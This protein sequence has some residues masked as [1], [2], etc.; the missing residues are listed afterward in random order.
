MCLCTVKNPIWG[1][2]WNPI[3][4]I[5]MLGTPYGVLLAYG[6]DLCIDHHLYLQFALL[7][8]VK[9]AFF[10]VVHLA[11]YQSLIKHSVITP[12]QQHSLF[13]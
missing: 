10:E 9:D 4:N 11:E 5:W 8:E 2:A 12:Q 13:L 7:V 3:W 6:V 1:A